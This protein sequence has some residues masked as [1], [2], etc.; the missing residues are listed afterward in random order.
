MAAEVMNLLMSSRR[1]VGEAICMAV[2][3]CMEGVGR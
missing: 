1:D 3:E 2:V